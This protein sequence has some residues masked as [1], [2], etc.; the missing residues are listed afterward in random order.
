[1]SRT[2]I[3]AVVTT[4]NNAAT[5]R[6]CLASLAWCDEVVLL[7]SDSTDATRDI[8]AEF[9]ARITIEPFKGYGP[10]KQSAIDKA[11]HDWILLLD[12]DESL[13]PESRAVI[14]HELAAPRATNGCSG[15]G[16]TRP[17]VRTG[18]CACSAAA[19]AA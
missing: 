16:R 18:N 13:A 1:M 12:A 9:D 5:L 15:A 17:R 14:E 8:A 19:A 6:E 4:F 2:P 10:Q 7:D 3:S 11:T